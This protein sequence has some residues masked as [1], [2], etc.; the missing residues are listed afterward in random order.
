[1]KY[2]CKDC[3]LEMTLGK[4]PRHIYTRH[5]KISMM[6]FYKLYLWDGVEDLTCPYCG[7]ER[8]AIRYTRIAV[9]CGSKRCKSEFSR[10]GVYSQMQSEGDDWHRRRIKRRL[11]VNPDSY[12]ISGILGMKALHKIRRDNNG[13]RSKCERLF[14]ERAKLEFPELRAGDTLFYHSHKVTEDKLNIIMDFSL[15]SQNL[16]I[17][18]DGSHHETRKFKDAERDRLLRETKG[19][20][21]LRIPNEE[22]LNDIE[23]CIQR[24]KEMTV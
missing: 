23:S 21:V 24:V 14:Y 22:V 9:T 6:E 7:D 19:W 17:E 10:K 5:R 2:K 11:E 15:R 18:I 20:R 16:C 1:M 12:R 8:M 4:L 3:G 13:F